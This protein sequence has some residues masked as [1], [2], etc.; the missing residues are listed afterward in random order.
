MALDSKQVTSRVRA[1]IRVCSAGLQACRVTAVVLA[2]ALLSS[3]GVSPLASAAAG[4]PRIVSLVPSATEMLFAIGAGPQVVGVSSY[5]TYPPETAKLP[6]LGALLDPD[7]ERILSL[8]PDLAVVYATQTDLE[9]QLRRAGI[10]IF[11]YRHAGLADVTQTIRDLGSRTGHR[12][13][14]EAVVSRIDDGL[15]HIRRA[16]AGLPRPKTLLV[17]GR[18]R[19]ALRGIYASGGIGFLH[20][21]LT[22]AG[23][24]NVFA[25]V[26]LQ[27]VQATTESII[28]RRP[29]AIIEV[30]SAETPTP[31]GAVQDEIKT[32]SLLGSVPAVR[33]GRVFYLI[34]DRLVVPGPR[35]AE[36]VRLL[37]D[38]LHPGAVQ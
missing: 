9:R 4:P 1:G 12:N 32:W 6:K 36:G 33:N 14:A 35:I 27:A 19:L 20:D 22:I 15:A 26:K 23:G 16:V 17:F 7:V 29:D 24:D 5:D 11:E 37:A 8:R 3:V 28:A 18:E 34:D 38:V 31:R 2:I 10:D 21:M 30:H 25:D 13:E